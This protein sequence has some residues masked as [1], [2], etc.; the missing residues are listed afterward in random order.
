M[1]V[2]DLIC[3]FCRILLPSAIKTI[4]SAYEIT[5]KLELVSLSLATLCE[6]EN[7]LSCPRGIYSKQ[8]TG[9]RL[10]T[11]MIE[12]AITQERFYRNSG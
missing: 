1:K 5:D 8:H 3:S 12:I 11:D 7:C 4:S 9:V 6:T 2:F 10:V